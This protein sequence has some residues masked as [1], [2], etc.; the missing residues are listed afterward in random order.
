MGLT[1]ALGLSR[2][3][4]ILIHNFIVEHGFPSRLPLNKTTGLGEETLTFCQVII[5][6]LVSPVAVVYG[7]GVSKL[8][9]IACHEETC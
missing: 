3:S 8:H 4:K 2:F 7:V 5:G 6:L 9:T 1:R